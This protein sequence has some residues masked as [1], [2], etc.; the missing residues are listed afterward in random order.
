MKKMLIAAICASMVLG[1]TCISAAA[2]TEPVVWKIEKAG[3]DIT[4]PQEW[5]DSGRYLS[6]KPYEAMEG[7]ILTNFIMYDTTEEE[8]DAVGE[9]LGDSEEAI[10]DWLGARVND[11][12][13]TASIDDSLGV[14]GFLEET[15]KDNNTTV[16]ELG[17]EMEE[18]G[19][20]DGWT[21]YHVLYDETDF[22]RPTPIEGTEEAVAMVLDHVPDMFTNT[23]FYAPIPDPKTEEGTQISFKTV[24]FDG[25]E[26][27]SAEIFANNDYTMI[28]LWMSW[29]SWCVKE[30]PELEKMN[31]ELAEDNCGIIAVM[32]DGDEEDKLEIGKGIV[33]DAGA[34]FPVLIP[35][36]EMKEQL[37][38]AGYPTTI[39][40]DSEGIVIGEPIVGMNLQGYK[41]RM[42]ALISG[43]F[44]DTAEEDTAEEDTA[45]EEET[46]DAAEAEA[47]GYTIKVQNEDG[48]PVEEVSVQFCSDSTCMMGETDENGIAS[49]D[50]PGGT[51][52]LHIVDVP[53]E[54]EDDAEEYDVP[55]TAG[56]VV[57]TLK[58]A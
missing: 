38:A 8:M 17:V 21:F 24:D 49:F 19:K 43:A 18:I 11:L 30:M 4:L 15:A 34:T 37:V 53:E 48:E 20:A 50:V 9:E 33:A 32:L 44:W 46:A 41:D 5:V 22:R 55:E 31:A 35:N 6:Y 26:V 58:K 45:A 57:V 16:E 51:Y 52:T 56:T 47:S 7:V 3:M 14:D 54:Y 10:M 12:A 13:M 2:D 40:V 39:F 25:N 29:C 42:D 36:D 23:S 1:S 28:N 27:D